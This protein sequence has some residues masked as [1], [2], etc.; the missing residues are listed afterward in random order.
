MGKFKLVLDLD[1]INSDGKPH[2]H[3]AGD[4]TFPASAEYRMADGEQNCGGC[5]FFEN[6]ICDVYDAKAGPEMTCNSYEADVE[7]NPGDGDLGNGVGMSEFYSTNGSVS[8]DKDLIWKTVLRTGTW[9][10][11]PGAG[12]RPIPNPLSVVRGRSTNP[13]LTVGLEDIVE[14]FQKGAIEHVT[15]PLSHEDKVNENT[16]YVKQLKISDDPDRPGQAVLMA[17]MQFTDSAIKDKIKSGSIANTSVGL[18][19]DY[20]RKD[21]GTKFGT[22]LAHIALTNR[23]WINGM[24]PFSLAEGENNDISSLEFSEE[25][26]SESV[27]IDDN[28]VYCNL[29]G[30]R[31]SAKI[32]TS[33]GTSFELAPKDEWEQLSEETPQVTNNDGE[34]MSK[35]KELEGLEL[36]DEVA[37]K[38]AQ[39]LE[40]KD[41]ELTSKSAELTSKD[42][43]LTTLRTSNADLAKQAH[44]D[45]VDK[46]IDELKG[47]G[48]SELPGFLAEVRTVLLADNGSTKLELSEDN[49][50]V[51][52][53]FTDVVNRLIDALPKKDGKINFSEQAEN[54]G[55]VTKPD[56]DTTGEQ[57]SAEDKYAEA[58]EDLYGVKPEK[59]SK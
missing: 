30:V 32:V 25:T 51:E 34:T 54:V 3:T 28:K 8:E 29:D 48:L 20:I 40:A 22:A 24:K 27:K 18:H 35:I 52:V 49:K 5:I 12:Q 45:T 23:P 44:V 43:E 1:G 38:V 14:S 37:A 26:H 4:K 2:A 13:R 31:Y 46:R 56:K 6:G 9:R 19:Y 10:Y 47:L 17:G 11:R 58:Y 55:L 16:G 42:E 57:K 59:P 50:T 21:D 36:S 15:I 39:L 33:D 7:D 53:G 41:E